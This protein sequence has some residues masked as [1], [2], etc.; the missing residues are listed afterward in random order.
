MDLPLK[1]L[2]KYISPG[3][4]DWSCPV[5]Q[6]VVLI[7][8]SPSILKGA[9]SKYPTSS[10]MLGALH[11]PRTRRKQK[12]VKVTD[13]EEISNF[14]SIKMKNDDQS[15]TGTK[16]GSVSRKNIQPTNQ[17]IY[18]GSWFLEAAVEG[19]V[20]P[21]AGSVKGSGPGG[22]TSSDVREGWPIIQTDPKELVS[23]FAMIVR[24]IRDFTSHPAAL[25]HDK[26][27][28][29]IFSHWLHQMQEIEELHCAWD[30]MTPTDLW[31]ARQDPVAIRCYLTKDYA[32]VIHKLD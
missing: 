5:D 14:Y 21:V 2:S 30:M 22:A 13:N 8:Q 10:H 25:D 16:T 18:L 15:P 17:T 26:A 12:H 3:P 9:E 31:E 24:K 6:L 32:V 23:L 1:V 29:I 28:P 7:S 19:S 4:T 27:A 20:G 11:K